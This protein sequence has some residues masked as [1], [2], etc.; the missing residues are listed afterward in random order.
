[1]AFADLCAF[2][3]RRWTHVAAWAGRVTALAGFKAPFASLAMED[4]E[5]AA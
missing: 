1:V 2:D 3:R 5:I 4:D